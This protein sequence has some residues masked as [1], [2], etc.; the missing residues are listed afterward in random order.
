MNL[1]Y[2]AY[3]GIVVKGAVDTVM[4]AGNV[5]VDGN[6]FVGSKSGGKF[7]RRDLSNVIR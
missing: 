3:E 1:D 5:I 4:L 6:Q 2:S 7:V